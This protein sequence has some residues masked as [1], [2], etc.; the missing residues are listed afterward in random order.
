MHTGLETLYKRTLNNLSLNKKLREGGKHIAI[1]FGFPRL[2]KEFPG[3]TQ[4]TYHIV[5][6]S[7]KV[8]KSQ[9]TDALY[10]FNVVNF[11]LTQPTNITAK[12]FSFNLEMSSESKMRQV[13][14]YRLFQKHK[15]I[16]SPRKLQSLLEDYILSDDILRFLDEDREWFEKFEQIVSYQDNIRNP[17]GIFKHMVNYARDNGNYYD[18]NNQIIPMELILKNDETIN[19]TI[20]RY[21][22]SN[23]DEYRIVITDHIGLL[24]QEKHEGQM[25]NLYDTIAKWSSDYCIRLRNRFKYTIVN[26]Q[27]QA[28]MSESLDAAKMDMKEPSAANLSD[29]KSSSKDVNVLLALHSPFRAKQ[30]TYMGYNIEKLRDNFRQ[31][32][33]LLDREG[34][35]CETS[36]YF[37]GACNVFKE[38]PAVEQMTPE[39]Y[40]EIT[41]RQ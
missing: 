32:F 23:P 5:S 18:K 30:R 38:L 34:S 17:T 22:M 2:D 41:K 29:Y 27:Q 33:I 37:N 14:A 8:G 26:V 19:K 7:Q 12:I 11:I 10:I 40:D 3:I 6:A 20:D 25:M 15:I 28:A 4:G 35:A 1:P 16:L 21:E 9:I 24:N 36:L 13:M 31:L 39:L